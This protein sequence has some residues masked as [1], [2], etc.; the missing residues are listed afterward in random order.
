MRNQNWQ[1]GLKTLVCIPVLS[2][3]IGPETIFSGGLIFHY[4]PSLRSD[5]VK[6]YKSICNTMYIY[7]KPVTP[8]KV[9]L[10]FASKTKCGWHGWS[11]QTKHDYTIGNFQWPQ[12]VPM[13]NLILSLAYPLH[14]SMDGLIY[15]WFNCTNLFFL[16]EYQSDS[17]RHEIFGS[18]ALVL[19]DNMSMSLTLHA[20]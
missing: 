18:L 10:K 9:P 16:V 8:F 2:I 15:T 11:P 3:K 1:G 6:S 17:P 5:F 4:R 7:M 14:N 20:V 12:M 13:D 19:L